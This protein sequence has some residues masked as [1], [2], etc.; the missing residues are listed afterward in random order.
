MHVLVSL[1]FQRLYQ[2]LNILH[3]T[4]QSFRDTLDRIKVP[5]GTQNDPVALVAL[6]ASKSNKVF[7]IIFKLGGTFEAD[8]T[9]R[10]WIQIVPD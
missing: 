5:V 2:L 3:E 6:T 9:H 7:I 8:V 4:P 1:F 10:T